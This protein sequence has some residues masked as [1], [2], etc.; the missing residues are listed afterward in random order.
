VEGTGHLVGT[1]VD[2]WAVASLRFDGG[3]LAHLATGVA[4]DQPPRL[5]V[6]GSEGTI[7]LREPW[8]PGVRGEPGIEVIRPGRKPERIRIKPDRGLYAYEADVVASAIAQGQV[9]AGHPACTWDDSLANARTL[10]RWRAAIGVTYEADSLPSPVA[11]RLSKPASIGRHAIRGTEIDVSRIVLGTM[12]AP[13][14]QSLACQLAMFDAY[15]EAGGTTFD[16]AFIYADGESDDALGRWQSSRGVREEIE[17]IT[18]GAHTP[19]DFPDRVRPQLEISLDR[20]RTDHADI[21]LLHRDNVDVPVGEFV[22]ALED[23]R[24]E[25][26]IRMYGGSNWTSAR[27]DEANAWAQANGAQGF[28]VVSNQFSLARMITPTYPGTLGANEPSFLVWLRKSAMTNIAWSSQA[29][30]FFAGLERDG[31]LA[32]A[33]FSDD[34]LERRRRAEELAEDLEVPPVTLALAWVLHVDVPIVPIIGPQSLAHLRTSLQA[35]D[36]T[37][38][39]E[40]VRWLDLAP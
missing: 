15:T 28:T 4:V 23:L 11:G 31:F 8:L 21:Y 27:I 35:L 19:D 34:N 32:H 25:G 2:G 33:W 12:T 5:R 13:G 18:K 17:I 36:V 1:G 26:R 37:L 22:A 30:G 3:I 7:V 38:T 6:H 16:T 20:L 9:E 29:S 24:R 39:P 10:D 14:I 40:Q